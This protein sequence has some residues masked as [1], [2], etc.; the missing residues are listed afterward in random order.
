[1]A[2]KGGG[3]FVVRTVNQSDNFIASIREQGAQ[4]RSGEP[5]SSCNM[6]LV[7]EGRAV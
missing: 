2:F 1:M 3:T 7:L 5:I 4:I 6:R